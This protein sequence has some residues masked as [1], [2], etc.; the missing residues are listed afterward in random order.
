MVV[1]SISSVE[2]VG[3]I[4]ASSMDLAVYRLV[5]DGEMWLPVKNR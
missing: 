2:A 3:R 4:V 1:V 5:L